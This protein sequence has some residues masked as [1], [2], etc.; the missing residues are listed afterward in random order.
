MELLDRYLQ[1]V[2]KHLPGQMQDD[3]IAELRV[4]LES[5]LEDRE[6]GL[7]RP[8]TQ[9][10]VEAWLKELGPPMQVAAR[11]KPHQY[12]IGPAVFPTYL[13]V[14]RTAF[15]WSM[16]IYS[17]VS[18]VLIFSAPIPSWTAALEAL[19][20]VP[21]VLLSVATWVTLT[22]A[23][24][25]F[26]IERSLITWPSNGAIAAD[27][28]PRSLPALEK[29][30]ADGVKRR[31]YAQA[32]AEVVFGVLFLIWLALIPSHPY[33]LFGPGAVYMH[34]SPFQL[35]PVWV[36]F[37]WWVVGINVLQVG[38][39]GW[40]LWR[41]NWQRARKAQGIA[42]KAIGLIPMVV[43]VNAPDH[44]WILLKHPELD[45]AQYRGTVDA[46]NQW[47]YRG[48]LM[49]LAIASLQMLWDLGQLSLEL[50]RKRSA[51]R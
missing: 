29:N 35:A 24:F 4:N 18:A 2:R 7:G 50:Y 17:I 27:W 43:L 31:S 11:Y 33:L 45:S 47:G 9:D 42:I 22:F 1:A 21:V 8:L 10:E 3:I 20:R 14:L 34:I 23:A 32:V 46:I 28:S 16:V 19:L 30:G 36:S 51:A 15:F 49:V 39:R 26:A 12:L 5:Q 41:G 44:I 13:F 38:W 6:A 37:Y 40:D 48:L 25:E